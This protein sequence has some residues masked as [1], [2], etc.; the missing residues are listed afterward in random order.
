[1]LIY[2]WF[3]F[4]RSFFFFPCLFFSFFSHLLQSNFADPPWDPTIKEQVKELQ[5]YLDEQIE[6]SRKQL[7]DLEAEEQSRL[8]AARKRVQELE[9]EKLRLEKEL[10]E[11]R[12][13][14][15]PSF[16]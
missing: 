5:S 2:F 4:F 14:G 6:K 8:D 7:E 15:S 12:Q 3:C 11:L 13:K 16:C 1:M 9:D 10:L